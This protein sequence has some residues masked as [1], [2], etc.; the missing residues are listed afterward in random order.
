MQPRSG[1]LGL[2]LAERDTPKWVD[3]ALNSVERS[4][5]LTDSGPENWADRNPK[6]ADDAQNPAEP[7]ANLEV[8]KCFKPLPAL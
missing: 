2:D 1:E 4:S 5:N 7:S 6:L 3:R 8:H